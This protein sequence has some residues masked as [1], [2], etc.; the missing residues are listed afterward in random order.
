MVTATLKKKPNAPKRKIGEFDYL[1]DFVPHDYDYESLY[2]EDWLTS[3]MAKWKI[4]EEQRS[5][6]KSELIA[7]AKA[8]HAI[9]MLR[10]EESH[11][12]QIKILTQ[13]STNL[14]KAIESIADINPI[15]FENLMAELEHLEVGT[16]PEYG[17]SYAFNWY[18]RMESSP[19]YTIEEHF[20]QRPYFLKL[21]EIFSSVEKLKN[22]ADGLKDKLSKQ[23]ETGR[24]PIVGL[25]EWAYAYLAAFWRDEL[26]RRITFTTF[27]NAGKRLIKSD[28]YY[29]LEDAIK[30]LDP[31]ISRELHKIMQ[32]II[33][34]EQKKKKGAI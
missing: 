16:K 5:Y 2:S 34:E 4:E 26:E 25:D 32:Y 20:K 31:R 14:G 10:A 17:D 13:L 6:L 3:F 27:K 21:R 18:M 12:A 15:V 24:P 23:N 11:N 22:S 8:Y 9:K 1:F 28:L 30:P 33:R 7:G 19:N 29:F